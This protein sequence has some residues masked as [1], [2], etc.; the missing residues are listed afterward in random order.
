MHKVYFSNDSSY[1]GIA[2]KSQKQLE[3]EIVSDDDFKKYYFSLYRCSPDEDNDF[4]RRRT[5]IKNIH[6]DL[7]IP[8]GKYFI[9]LGQAA[10]EILDLYYYSL[11][12]FEDLDEKSKQYY[13]RR[14]ETVK[15]KHER[16]RSFS[17]DL[18]EGQLGT[19]D[20]I[21]FYITKAFANNQII[22]LKVK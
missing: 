10:H 14:C 15:I 1:C 5:G 21:E 17:I 16:A 13:A 22:A 11:S 18:T 6:P 4:N 7:S 3:S 8:V 19:D 9:L 20:D 2:Y 12:V